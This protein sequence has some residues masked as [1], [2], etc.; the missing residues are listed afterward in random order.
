MVKIKALGRRA[1]YYQS[2]IDMELLLSGET[3]ENL[4]NTYVIFIC[5][6]DPF[7]AE[8]YC[9]TFKN[10]CLEAPE[11][12]QGDGRTSIFLSTHGKNDTEVSA[13]MVKFLKYVKAD[14]EESMK[15]FEDE[16]VA[17]IQQSV[18]HIKQSRGM[19]EH[20][21][22]FEE[23]LRE[24]RQDALEKGRAEGVAKGIMTLLKELGNIPS[25][26]EKQ[27]AEEKN[28]DVLTNWLKVAA[29]AENVEY[30]QKN[31]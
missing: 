10:Q 31:M 18:Q 5:D 14:L 24:E 27:I 12:N 8:R 23:L 28:L 9:Y 3:Y 30:F 20:F 1:R 15:D 6:F 13:P 29:Q 4:P 22:T 21:M 11:L 25:E 17:T 2:Q 7:G 16:F 26:L 19:E